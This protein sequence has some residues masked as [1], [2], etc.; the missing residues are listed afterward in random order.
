VGGARRTVLDLSAEVAVEV[1]HDG[2]RADVEA[3]GG[4]GSALEA[5]SL[6]FS[7]GHVIDVL[8][9]GE[10]FISVERK[11]GGRPSRPDGRPLRRWPVPPRHV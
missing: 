11:V 7:G 1:R 10:L 5:A 3:L 4:F 6:P 8:H 9:D 2:T